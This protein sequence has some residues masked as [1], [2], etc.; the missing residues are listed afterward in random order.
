MFELV[1]TDEVQFLTTPGWPTQYP[2]NSNC[3]W[4]IRPTTEG[5]RVRVTVFEGQA[6]FCCDRLQVWQLI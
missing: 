6:E 3:Y 1:A 5:F 4:M 2:I